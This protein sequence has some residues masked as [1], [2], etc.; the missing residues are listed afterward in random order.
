MFINRAR[1][2]EQ[3][4]RDKDYFCSLPISVQEALKVQVLFTLDT[5][6]SL[7]PTATEASVCSTSPA[8]GIHDCLTD[9]N[10]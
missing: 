4:Q 9:R 8:V 1:I 6:L 3:N 10:N 7:Y 2:L 5:Q